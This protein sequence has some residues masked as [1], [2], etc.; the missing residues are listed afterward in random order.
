MLAVLVPSSVALF[1]A[2]WLAW[3]ARTCIPL[4]LYSLLSAMSLILYA[5]DKRRAARGER[6]I[7]ERTLHWI[8]LG[9][10]WFGALCAQSLFRHKTRKARFQLVTWLV[11]ASHQLGWL[12]WL[13]YDT[14]L[15][16]RF[17]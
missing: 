2:A 10:G 7:P 12:V 15:W 13:L 1:G 5:S 11:V 3:A 17:V 14:A 16:R 9:G 4:A 6:R 8:A